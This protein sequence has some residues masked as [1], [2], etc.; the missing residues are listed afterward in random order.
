MLL[1][2]LVLECVSQGRAGTQLHVF[3]SQLAL[4]MLVLSLF[5]EGP[6]AC[7]RLL[8]SY[9][10]RLHSNNHSMEPPLGH[11]LGSEDTFFWAQSVKDW[12]KGMAYS[13]TG[14]K[15]WAFRYGL[16]RSWIPRI[17]PRRGTLIFGSSWLTGSKDSSQGMSHGIKMILFILHISCDI[18]LFY[19]HICWYCPWILT[20]INEYT[21]GSSSSF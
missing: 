21:Y 17:W 9:Y 5:L 12:L 6:H 3:S 2:S 15:V 16:L 20:N 10:F 1:R 18:T 14:N 11:S 8:P 4:I 19:Y 7:K 13:V